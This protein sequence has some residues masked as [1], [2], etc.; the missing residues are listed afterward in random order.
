MKIWSVLVCAMLFATNAFGSEPKY[1]P[2]EIFVAYFKAMSV[3]QTEIADQLKAVDATD[4]LHMNIDQLNIPE[5]LH[6]F[7][8]FSTQSRALVV[9]APFTILKSVLD[10]D[11]VIY[12]ELLK[13][14]GEWRIQ[15]LDRTSPETASWLMRG[16]RIHPD[17]RL[18]ISPRALVGEWWYPCNSSVVL[19]ED[20]TGT[21]LMVGPGGI[22]PEQKPERFTW[23]VK[24][25]TLNLR[26][27]DREEKLEITSI[28][29]ERVRFK[30]SDRWSRTGWE[31]KD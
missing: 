25:T 6:P 15:N 3:R 10:S 4:T 31:R 13:E 19:K 24:G 28:D 11:E 22:D 30:P 23:K 9:A 18:D 26:F 1:S 17:V 20:G 21:E 12:A 7:Y 27:A 2:R 14:D 16:F 8:E 29:H 5:R